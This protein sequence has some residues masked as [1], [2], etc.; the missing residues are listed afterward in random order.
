M[1]NVAIA[2]MI[3]VL[4]IVSVMPAAQGDVRPARAHRSRLSIRVCSRA[5]MKL[6]TL[7]RAQPVAAHIAATDPFRHIGDFVGGGPMCFVRNEWVPPGEIRTPSDSK[8]M[9]NQ[10]RRRTPR[11]AVGWNTTFEQF[12]MLLSLRSNESHP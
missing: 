2:N 3:K 1:A 8:L 12:A 11:A 6:I 7:C 4:I 10:A 9:H 5:C